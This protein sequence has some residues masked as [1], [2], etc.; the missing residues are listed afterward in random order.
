MISIEENAEHASILA[1]SLSVTNASAKEKGRKCRLSELSFAPG[2]DNINETGGLDKELSESTRALNET[3]SKHCHDEEPIPNET[4]E[5]NKSLPS[6]F[7]DLTKEEL[8]LILNL[9][10]GMR[11]DKERRKLNAKKPK[12]AP[13][14][15][16]SAY[17][18]F[19][20]KERLKI[21]EA[22]EPGTAG[23]ENLAKTV[24]KRWKALPSEEMSYFQKMASQDSERYKNEMEKYRDTTKRKKMA[25]SSRAPAMMVGASARGGSAKRGR[26]DDDN[27]ANLDT[28]AIAAASKTCSNKVPR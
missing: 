11:D 13:K 12:D 25:L 17:N 4:D 10:S 16:L 3:T 18:I 7:N 9:R 15:P 14:R 22:S 2:Q 24:G 28:D 21:L 23:F 26:A 5:R 6:P 1:N 27:A 19:F 20:K 8:E